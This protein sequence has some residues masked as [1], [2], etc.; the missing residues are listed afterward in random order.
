MGIAIARP[1]VGEKGYM[2][3]SIELKTPGG[4]SSLPPEHT[5]STILRYFNV[6][7]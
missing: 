1:A 6:I 5:V 3:V 7:F 2:D 4:H